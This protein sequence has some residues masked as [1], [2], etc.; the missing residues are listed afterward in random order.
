M[1]CLKLRNCSTV[2]FWCESAVIRLRRLRKVSL[3]GSI[4]VALSQGLIHAHGKREIN[5]LFDCFPISWSLLMNSR[6]RKNQIMSCLSLYEWETRVFL[7]TPKPEISNQTCGDTVFSQVLIHNHKHF[8]VVA[9]SSMQISSCE[10]NHLLY[11]FKY[12]HSLAHSY[13]WRMIWIDPLSARDSYIYCPHENCCS[14]EQHNHLPTIKCL[15]S[16]AQPNHV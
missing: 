9:R 16:F 2:F 13:C 15:R 7:C 12:L 6:T 5:V 10:R 3:F 8:Q 1:T 4:E 14:S 11:I